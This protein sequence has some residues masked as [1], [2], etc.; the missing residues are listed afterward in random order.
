[1]VHHSGA[2]AAEEAKTDDEESSAT[3]KIDPPTKKSKLAKH[4]TMVNTAKVMIFQ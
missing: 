1:M 3:N 4:S 2:E